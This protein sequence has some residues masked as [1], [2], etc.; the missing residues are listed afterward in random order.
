MQGEGQRLRALRGTALG[1]ANGVSLVLLAVLATAYG[2]ETAVPFTSVEAF[3]TVATAWTSGPTAAGPA[4]VLGYLGVLVVLASPA[5]SFLVRPLVEDT[6]GFGSRT[7]QPRD[8]SDEPERID[9]GAE[10]E[11]EGT[12]DDEEIGPGTIEDTEDGTRDALEGDAED[13]TRDATDDG[14]AFIWGS[15]SNA[16]ETEAPRNASEDESGFVWGDSPGT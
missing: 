14:A 15:P 3:L 7:K 1:F 6:L 5:W 12:R 11:D 16:E 8:P 9:D 13:G 4:W 2:M 10:V